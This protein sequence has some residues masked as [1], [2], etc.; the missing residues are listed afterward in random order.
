MSSLSVLRVLACPALPPRPL[1][2]GRLPQRGPRHHRSSA[3][4]R[5]PPAH[6]RLVRPLHAPRLLTLRLLAIRARR[7]LSKKRIAQVSSHARGAPTLLHFFL[8]AFSVR[9]A[10]SAACGSVPPAAC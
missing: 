3:P 5:R 2:V 1:A 8:G 4:Q 9:F 6:R 10:P 7:S